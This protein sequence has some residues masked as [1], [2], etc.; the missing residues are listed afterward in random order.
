[1][2]VQLE[3]ISPIKK[4][5]IVEVEK[6]QIM[7]EWESVVKNF[8]KKVKL[9]GF[10]TGKI[11]VNV[12]VK[13]Y[14]PQIEEEVVSQ[15]INRT[16]PEALKETGIIP[17]AIPELDYPPLDKEAPFIYKAAIELKPEIPI[18][19]YKGLEVKKPGVNIT[20]EDVEKRLDCHPDE[21][22]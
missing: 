20:E 2:K 21:P 13:Y 10:R 15:I 16:Y 3:E 5:L 14:G 6:E 17:M 18:S 22:R 9:K 4:K 11:P 7:K 1:M 8:N 19:E 12:L